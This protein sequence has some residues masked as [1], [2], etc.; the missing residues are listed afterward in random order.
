MNNKKIFID[1]LKEYTK[2]DDDM[3]EPKMTIKDFYKYIDCQLKIINGL[4]NKIICKKYVPELHENK[5]GNIVIEKIW[6]EIKIDN[7]SFNKTL[8]PI[9]VCKILY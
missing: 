7:I 1:R 8:S 3:I 2:I 6:C 9:I 5:I 4:D